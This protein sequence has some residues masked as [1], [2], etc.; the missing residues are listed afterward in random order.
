MSEDFKQ[1]ALLVGV[2]LTTII[3]A[4]FCAF[5]LITALKGC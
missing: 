4:F 3:I 1:D 5:V 2:I